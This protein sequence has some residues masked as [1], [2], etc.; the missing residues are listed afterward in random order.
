M[1]NPAAT[2]S[3]L[4]AEIA[5]WWCEYK[6]G[7]ERIAALEDEVALRMSEAMKM[8]GD[9]LD[10]TAE[11]DALREDAERYRWLRTRVSG[12]RAV[13][14]GRPATFAFPGPLDL[15]PIGDIMRGSV[16]QHLD[17]AI[18]AARKKQP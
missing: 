8:H 7:C 3:Q 1:T 17:A 15:P 5:R 13:G 6:N 14:S 2:K 16:A 9:I 18:D 4:R 10:L 11:R 12:H